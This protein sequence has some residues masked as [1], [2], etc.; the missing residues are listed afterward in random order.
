M[1]ASFHSPGNA[2]VLSDWLYSNVSDG[3]ICSAVSFNSLAEILSGPDALV[4][5]SE[6]RA[7]TTSHGEREILE[8]VV[9]LVGGNCGRGSTVSLANMDIK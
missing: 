3:A 1:F 4:T 6:R 9:L 2:P 7:A 8:N 5:S